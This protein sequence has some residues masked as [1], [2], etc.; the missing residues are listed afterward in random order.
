MRSLSSFALQETGSANLDPEPGTSG[1]DKRPIRVEQG[2]T[3][4]VVSATGI[5][6]NVSGSAK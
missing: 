5:A 6:H 4:N 1:S 2:T 3:D